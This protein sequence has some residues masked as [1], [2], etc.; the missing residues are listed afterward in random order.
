MADFLT[1]W[2]IHSDLWNDSGLALLYLITKQI[3]KVERACDRIF[4]LERLASGS[5]NAL[6][7]ICWE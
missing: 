4:E 7:N 2:H 5:E 6:Q 1:I 3:Q